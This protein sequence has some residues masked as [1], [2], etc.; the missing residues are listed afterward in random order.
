MSLLETEPDVSGTGDDDQSELLWDL[1][2]TNPNY[3]FIYYN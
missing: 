2:A 1:G 3:S